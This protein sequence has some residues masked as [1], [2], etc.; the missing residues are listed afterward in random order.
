MRLFGLILSGNSAPISIAQELLVNVGDCLPLYRGKSPEMP[1][2]GLCEN[3]LRTLR[4]FVVAFTLK[5][6]AGETTLA[7]RMI[8]PRGQP[9]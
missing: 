1:E 6:L 3:N 4:A 2:E 9:C 8:E 7:A 5:F